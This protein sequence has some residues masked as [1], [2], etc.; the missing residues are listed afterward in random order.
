M[1]EVWPVCVAA[2]AA[3]GS[4]GATRRGARAM[5]GVARGAHWP[6]TSPARTTSARS[7]TTRPLLADDEVLVPRPD[8]RGGRGRVV[9]G[10]PRGRGEGRGRVRAARRRSSTLERGDRGRQLPHRAARHPRAATSTRRSPRAPHAPRRRD[11]TSA[12]RSTSTWRRR[13]PGPS[14]A[15]TA[16]S[17]SAR[18][19][20]TRPRCRPSSRTCSHVPAQQGRRARRRA[21]AAASAARRRRATRLAALARWRRAKTGRP[22]RVQLDRDLDMTLTGKRHPFLARVRGRLRRRGPRPRAPRVQLVSDG[23]WALDLS[24][25]D[26]RPRAL[27]PRQRLLHPGGRLRRPGGEDEHRLEH[28]VPRLRRAAGDGGHRGDHRPHRPR[29]SACRPE[30]VR[31]RN[32]YRGTGETNTTHYGQEIERQP[33]PARSGTQ[34][35]ASARLRRARARR[36][37]AWNAAQ[38]ARQARASR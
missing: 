22:V 10:V 35:E 21:W 36:S 4:S 33:H 25:V 15:R 12:G 31:E 20:S 19:R 23:G 24:R 38:P 29:G 30:V 34:L 1:L 14:A 32:L 8:G 5:P 37:R 27:P 28:R 6:R 2:R 16:T 13:P 18:R 17:S 26:L 11:S 9:R 3:R 7:G